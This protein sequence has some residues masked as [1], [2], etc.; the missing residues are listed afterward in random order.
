MK[1]RLGLTI[2]SLAAIVAA[3]PACA[4]ES[5][6]QGPATEASKRQETPEKMK[7]RVLQHI[8]ARIQIL[9]TAKSCVQA[10][11]DMAS[12]AV[13]HARERKQTKALRDKDRRE[14]RQRPTSETGSAPR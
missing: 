14:I 5:P 13:C 2:A 1:S 11:G 9:Q 12:M 7:E 10:A 6:R 8:D 3:F 4:A